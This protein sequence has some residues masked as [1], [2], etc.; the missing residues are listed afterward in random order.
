MLV[1]KYF[2]SL[3]IFVFLLCGCS[4]PPTVVV[5]QPQAVSVTQPSATATAAPSATS[6]AAFTPIASPT[7]S[8]TP[9][10]SASP[11]LTLP[12]QP[13]Q[14]FAILRGVV[15]PDKVSCR[16][17]PGAM[18]LYLYGLVKGATQDIIGRTEPAAWV[19][20]R[21]R[22]D[23]KSCWVKAEFMDIKGDVKSVEM[24]YPDKY[25]LPPSNQ[26]YRIPWDVVALREG[27]QV[28]VTWKSEARRAGDEESA[29]SVLYVVE[30]WVCQGGELIFLPIGAYIPQI[31]VIDEPG[32]TQPSH[33][34][35]FFSE[36]HGYTGPSQVPW[37]PAQ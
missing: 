22:G 15:L 23:D 17:G 8:P 28:T 36:K 30:T 18:Y 35:V 29:S 7:Q 13:P 4:A 11:T 12:T 27:S 5:E 19:L 34:R 21:S 26:G 32:C 25:V 10:P 1:R 6:T 14:Q 20:T 9:V 37:P 3:M 16:Y 31:K 24:V 2:Y 33:A